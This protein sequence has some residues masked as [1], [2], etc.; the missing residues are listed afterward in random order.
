MEYHDGTIIQ[1]CVCI[2]MIY[3]CLPLHRG[4][5]GAYIYITTNNGD[6]MAD[7]YIYGDNM[8]IEGIFSLQHTLCQVVFLEDHFPLNWLPSGYLT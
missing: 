1:I 6:I 8:G 7:I 3:I 5:N 2:I 4:Y